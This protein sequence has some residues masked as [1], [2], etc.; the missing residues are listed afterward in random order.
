M[1]EPKTKGTEP[2]FVTIAFT[3][4]EVQALIVALT[5]AME[6]FENIVRRGCDETGSY[7]RLRNRIWDLHDMVTRV[8]K[9]N[10]RK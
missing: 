10:V 5:E 7:G 6:S 1:E 8:I 3:K 2:Q 9:Q 4:R